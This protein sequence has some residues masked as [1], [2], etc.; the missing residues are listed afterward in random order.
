[1]VGAQQRCEKGHGTG[2]RTNRFDRGLLSGRDYGRN[3][4]CKGGDRSIRLIVRI[5]KRKSGDYGMP[6]IVRFCILDALGG[7]SITFR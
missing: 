5:P 1:M 7:L 3:G 6:L 2:A 4:Y